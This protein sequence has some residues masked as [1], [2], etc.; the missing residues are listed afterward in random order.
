MLQHPNPNPNPND[1]GRLD[2]YEEGGGD[3]EVEDEVV[4]EETET[5]RDTQVVKAVEEVEMSYQL[6]Y[7][8]EN[9]AEDFV[10]S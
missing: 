1:E 8:Y 10:L 3:D 5:E 7:V 9:E 6:P 2:D 4:D